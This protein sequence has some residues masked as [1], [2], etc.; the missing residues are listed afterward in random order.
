MTSVER[1]LWLIALGGMLQGEFRKEATEY[2]HLDDGPEHDLRVL[3]AA[4]RGRDQQRV[5]AALGQWG[6]EKESGKSALQAIMHRLRHFAIRRGVEQLGRELSILGA[7]RE[8]T[9]ERFG[10]LLA[11]HVRQL[12]E[13]VKDESCNRGRD[14]TLE[15]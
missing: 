2:L 13:T 8:A 9:P 10:E 7:D 14:A 1:D 11:K 12:S 15:T 5:Y 6:I 4:I 3:F